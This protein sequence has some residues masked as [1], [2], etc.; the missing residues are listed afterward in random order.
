MADYAI[1]KPVSNSVFL[2]HYSSK[3][4]P[5]A[6]L[7]AVPLNLT[8]VALYNRLIV[9]L[10]CFQLFCWISAITVII[11]TI[12]AFWLRSIPGLA[13]FLYLWKDTYILLALQQ[14]WSVVH[15]STKMRRAKYFYGILFG[16]GT[17]GTSVGGVVSGYLAPVWGSE[18]LLLMTLPIYLFLGAAYYW[19][20]KTSALE[21]PKNPIETPSQ[22]WDDFKLINKSYALQ[23]I[24]M[25]VVLMQLST[26][27]MEFRFNLLLEA[28]LPNQDLRT[29]FSGKFWAVVGIANLTL[30]FGVTFLLME[31][32]GLKKSQFFLPSF[33][34][35]NVAGCVI[36]PSFSMVA[37]AFGA[38]KIFDYSTFN[39]IKEMLYVPLSKEEKFKA[40]AL[41][42][43]FAYR[44]SK[45]V[46]SLIIILAQAFLV[47]QLAYVLT[48]TVLI[49]YIIWIFGVYIFN[50]RLEES[51]IAVN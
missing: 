17:F 11:N 22:K 46:A 15:S 23:L 45:A 19:M 43:V 7:L 31:L 34:L 27:L 37:Y 33:L 26:T 50:K 9:K 32:F 48:W 38:V 18:H 6:W 12:S 21:N 10:G 8:A 36:H 44:S 14:I 49:L 40:R 24:L 35:F 13:F 25:T 47:S 2:T 30:Q 20:L 4:F 5:Y 41:I 28:K 3:A 42:D 16:I 51:T 39:I 1:T 29:A